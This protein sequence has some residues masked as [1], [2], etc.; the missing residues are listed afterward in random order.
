MCVTHGYSC[1]EMLSTIFPLS[2]TPAS[3][4][5]PTRKTA[6]DDA[7][8]PS[9]KIIFFEVCKLAESALDFE[10]H[11]VC[12]AGCLLTY[13]TSLMSSRSMR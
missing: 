5:H 6:A 9:K 3:L 8:S 7:S 2:T 11:L 1:V 4:F 12:L 13:L 10:G